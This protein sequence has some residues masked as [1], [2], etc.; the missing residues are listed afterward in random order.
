MENLND[1]GVTA[2]L[3]GT[4]SCLKKIVNSVLLKIEQL[5]YCLI[6]DGMR[7]AWLISEKGLCGEVRARNCLLRLLAGSTWGAHASTLRTFQ[8]WPWS[9]VL[10][11]TPSQLPHQ[12]APLNDTMR[13]ISG[14][15]KPTRRE[16]SPALSGIPPAHLRGEH[17]TFNLALQA[18]LNTN[19]PLH[20]LV[21][22]SSAQSACI[23]DVPSAAMLRCCWTP[24]SISWSHGERH[25]KVPHHRPCF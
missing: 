4:K 10:R 18:Q 3:K 1:S 19:H 11:N 12:E 14:C 9:T 2:K 15:L 16:L 5:C 21:R 8:R 6:R 20:T 17:S 22:S 23:H 13:I 25:E 7:N 24:A